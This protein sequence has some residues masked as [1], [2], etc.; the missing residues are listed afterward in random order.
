MAMALVL[1]GLGVSVAVGVV[2]VVAVVTVDRLLGAV[3]VDDVPHDH[4]RQ[5]PIQKSSSEAK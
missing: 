5:K 4:H 3:M 1:A 2:G